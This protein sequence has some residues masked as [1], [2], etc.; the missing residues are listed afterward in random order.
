[1]G[2]DE[3]AHSQKEYEP[4]AALPPI[5]GLTSERSGDMFMMT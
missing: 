4:V 5:H 3:E 2:H 1:M